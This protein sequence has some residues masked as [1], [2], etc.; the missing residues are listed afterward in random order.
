MGHPPFLPYFPSSL[1]YSVPS[2]NGNMISDL[3]TKEPD[4]VREV[5]ENLECKI[6]KLQVVNVNCFS[7]Q[8]CISTFS[9]F[10]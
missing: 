5:P 10:T 2:I 3:R 4:V 8:N 9:F 7:T 6:T 1:F